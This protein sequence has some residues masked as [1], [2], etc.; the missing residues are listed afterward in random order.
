MK[1]RE[2]R[3]WLISQGIVIT[4][5]SKHEKL[6]NPANGKASHMPRHADEIGERLRK[7]IIK[8]LGL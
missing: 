2:F 6:R 8:Q 7:A 1:S 3:R 4:D 5:G